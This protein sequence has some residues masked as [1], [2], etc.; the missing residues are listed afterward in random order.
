MKGI[1]KACG[2]LA[3]TGSWP[4][5]ILSDKKAQLLNIFPLY[6]VFSPE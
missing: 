4:A 3:E 5:I 1:C 6:I 2:F